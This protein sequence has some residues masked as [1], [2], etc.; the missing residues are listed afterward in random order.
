MKSAWS[1]KVHQYLLPV[2]SQVSPT[3]VARQ[4]MLATSEPAFGSDSEYA[5]RNSP[6]AIRGR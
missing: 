2:I 1:A 3:R 5:P 4:L 6:F